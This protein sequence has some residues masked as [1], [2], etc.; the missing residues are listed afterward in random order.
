MALD[1]I[2]YFAPKG[3]K[4]PKTGVIPPLPL[5]VVLPPTPEAGQVI[6]GLISADGQILSSLGISSVSRTSTGRYQVSWTSARENEGYVVSRYAD[7]ERFNNLR[8]SRQS[9]LSE[10]N[11]TSFII[12]WREKNTLALVDTNFSISI[13]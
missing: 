13:Y 3:V 12:E 11:L 10:K 7:N 8:L 1:C 5:P 2:T 4:I 9:Q 6:W